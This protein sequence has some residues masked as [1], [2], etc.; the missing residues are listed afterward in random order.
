MSGI[1]F[2]PRLLGFAGLLPSLGCLAV[3]LFGPQ[4]WHDAARMIALGYALTILSFLGGT[5]WGIAASAPAAERRQAL[6]AVWIAS[7]VPPL[8]A[9]GI[10]LAGIVWWPFVETALVMT[11]AAIVLTLVADARL[12]A[13]APRWW[14]GLR[15]PL[16]LGLGTVTMA[17]ALI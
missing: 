2:W 13:L 16:S 4:D 10:V 6:A 1:P 12:G 11:G 8:V 17:S 15:I 9:A 3:L 14:Q 7:M 5:W